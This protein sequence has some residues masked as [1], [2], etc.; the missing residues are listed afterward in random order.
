LLLFCCFLPS[1]P[2]SSDKDIIVGAPRDPG[3]FGRGSVYVLFL[4]P[5]GT[6][7]A[8]QK[9]SDTAGNFQGVLDRFDNFGSSV[10][11]L[12]DLD[13]DGIQVTFPLPFRSFPIR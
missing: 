5:N 4:A 10:A 12:G 1:T 2:S 6:V 13:G 3:G 9:I 8:E 11:A 7:K